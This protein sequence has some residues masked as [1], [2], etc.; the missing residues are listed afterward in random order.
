MSGI[1]FNPGYVEEIIKK[2]GGKNS[3][4]TNTNIYLQIKQCKPSKNN[5]NV[6]ETMLSDTQFVYP[7]IIK[8]EAALFTI[9]KVTSFN[10]NKYIIINDYEPVQQMSSLVDGGNGLISSPAFRQIQGRNQQQQ[11]QPQQP[12]QPQQQQQQSMQ[13]PQ[14][15]QQ[16]QQQYNQPQLKMGGQQYNSGGYGGQFSNRNA[17]PSQMEENK[18]ALL[19]KPVTDISELTDM[20]VDWTICAMVKTKSEIRDWKKGANSEGRLFSMELSDNSTPC[21]TIKATVFGDLC[22]KLFGEF[23]TGKV[24]LIRG[25]TLKKINPTYNKLDHPVEIVFNHQTT[26]IESPRQFQ[27]LTRFN[28]TPIS[29]IEN[30][31]KDETIDVIG[32]IT[33]DSGIKDISTKNGP[34]VKKTLQI[35]DTTNT[36]IDITIWGE[37]CKTIPEPVVGNVIAVK[38]CKVSDFNGRSLTGTYTT[39]YELNP[40]YLAES[41]QIV[42]WNQING[43]KSATV[44]SKSGGSSNFPPPQESTISAMKTLFDNDYQDGRVFS[45]VGVLQR[46]PVISGAEPKKWY[47]NACPKCK[48]LI[49]ESGTGDGYVCNTCNEQCT[50]TLKYKMSLRL[51]DETGDVYVELMGDQG[52]HLFGLEA[53]QLNQKSPDEYENI[54]MEKL[55]HNY[56]VILKCTK[57]NEYPRYNIVKISPLVSNPDSLNKYIRALQEDVSFLTDFIQSIQSQ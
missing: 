24:Y 25:G 12:Q 19:N 33:N 39:T 22:L 1:N 5:Q 29:E 13:R 9:I 31:S 2:E 7:A 10:I 56:V 26:V 4:Y 16:P 14:Q 35:K 52:K 21:G 49:Q 54:M 8:R 6:F 36:M 53:D 40:Q 38:G 27:V 45:V 46:I 17:G 15:Q 42:E 47:Y 3:S 30:V 32:L 37:R 48:K 57:Y 20:T 34:T 43:G 44:L 23:Q 18:Q 55:S 11:Q 41:A 50:P 51:L 28:F